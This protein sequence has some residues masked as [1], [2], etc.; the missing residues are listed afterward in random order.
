MHKH[1]TAG[2]RRSVVLGISLLLA[3]VLMVTLALH[4]PIARA[5]S[6]FQDQ[7]SQSI[8]VLQNYYDTSSGYYNTGNNSNYWQTP[9]I[10]ETV[11][12]YMIR[13]GTNAYASNIS[14]TYDK[15]SGGNFLNGYYDD[16]GWYALSWIRAYDF[17]HDSRY[18]SMAQTIF[19]DISGGWDTST[20][21]G[22]VWWDKI[23]SYKNAIPNE[24][25]LEIAARLHERVSSDTAGG[26]G[27]N[28]HS[29]IDWATMEWS[30][31]NNSGMIN[32]SNIVNDGLDNSCHNNGGTTWT[33]NQGVVLGGL[34]ELYH[35]TGTNSYLTKAETL[36]NASTSQL[37]TNGILTEPC[38]TSNSCNNDQQIFK[39]IYISNLASLYSRDNNSTY[40]NFIAANAV[41]LWANDRNSS[42][43]FGLKWYGP[44]DTDSAAHQ[45]AGQSLLDSAIGLTPPASG[46]FATGFEKGNYQPTWTNTIDDGVYPDGGRSNITGVC[47]GI[48]DPEYAMRSNELA[49]TGTAALMYSGSDQSTSSSYAYAK[50]FDLSSM[51]LHVGTNTVLEYWI[52]PQSSQNSYVNTIS[53][54]N[55]S[56]IAIDLIF[57]DKTNL[58]DSGATDQNGNRAHPAYQC[59]HLTL[60]SWN[61]VIVNLGNRLSGKTINR[62]DV[63]YDQPANTGGFRGYIDD[64][65]IHN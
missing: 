29:Y 45:M 55:S 43:H 37:V 38:E 35:I 40:A 27:P 13:T 44:Y 21:G 25:F 26:S 36:A 32:S 41:S 22:G 33:Y 65:N 2:T 62:L 5:D 14:T 49:H 59:G 20:C 28:G 60:D 53:G 15:N 34:A 1:I 47:C 8:G 46:S 11:I 6:T 61:H 17:T 3:S 39:G 54:A 24:L 30:W 57:S 51:N 42:N 63:G 31:F 16:E 64:I 12:D 50:V 58:R 7:A 10:L 4:P 9:T 23:H 56:C 52:Y 18:L 48:S 19:A